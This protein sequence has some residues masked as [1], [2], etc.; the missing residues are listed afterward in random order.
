[1]EINSYSNRPLPSSKNPH[2]QNEAKCAT[3]L[4]KMSFICMRMKNHFH[5]KGCALNLV[6]YRGP[7]ELGNGLFRAENSFKSDWD[8]KILRAI[9]KWFVSPACP[10]PLTSRLLRCTTVLHQSRDKLPRW[11]CAFPFPLFQKTS[12][13]KKLQAQTIRRKIISEIVF[14]HRLIIDWYSKCM[15]W[16]I[17]HFKNFLPGNWIAYKGHEHS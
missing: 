11:F 16:W 5:I 2:F 10:P 13:D 4:V 6:W 8:G 7:R 1:M 17:F 9:L 15:C 12:T 3:F 14:Y